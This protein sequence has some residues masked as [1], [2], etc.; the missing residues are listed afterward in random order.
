MFKNGWYGA[1]KE[2]HP[3][4]PEHRS[5]TDSYFTIFAIADTTSLM[6]ALDVLMHKS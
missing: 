4:Y 3:A 2:R 5:H 6:Q 1:K